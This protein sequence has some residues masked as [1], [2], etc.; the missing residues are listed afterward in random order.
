MA[1]DPVRQAALTF[2]M[3]AQAGIQDSRS[4]FSGFHG[5]LLTQE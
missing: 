3:P 1:A 2:V 5:F 4:K